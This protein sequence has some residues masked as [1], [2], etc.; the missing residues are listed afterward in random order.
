M[1][2]L[3]V[4]T[5][6]VWNRSGPWETRRALI[7][8]ALGELA[9]DVVGLQEI[10]GDTPDVTQAHEIASGLVAPGGGAWH[11]A[12]GPAQAWGAVSF[13][14]AVLSRWPITET[15]VAPLPVTDLG[16]GADIADPRVVLLARIATPWGDLPFHT[17]HLSWKF[18][19]G[20]AREAQ[21]L[22]VAAHV[23]ATRRAGALPDVV[24]GDFNAQPDAAEIRF[25][26]GLQTLA[27]P[28]TAPRSTYFADAFAWAAD[29]TAKGDG[30]TFDRTRNPYAAYARE[31]PRRIDYVFVRGPDDHGRGEPLAARV[32][33][34]EVVDGVAP[35]DHYGVLAEI[36]V[37][38]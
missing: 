15:V 22:A 35:S 10:V 11:V 16:T 7:R 31:P 34:T 2:T 1:D 3:R 8:A 21:V 20:Y 25:M 36:S 12:F 29:E 28:G 4:L 17:T 5:L 19:E 30:A 33:C 14:N 13:G 24:V 18:H 38:R 9:P 32:V 27:R 26:T 37:S 6:N 23:E